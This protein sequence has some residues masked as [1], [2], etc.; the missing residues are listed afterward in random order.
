MFG[1]IS[2]LLLILCFFFSSRRRHTRCAL[3]TGVQT[4][5]LPILTAHISDCTEL[6]YC[7][8]SSRARSARDAIVMPDSFRHPTFHER[9]CL[10]SVGP[11]DKYGVTVQ[12]SFGASR[13]V[14]SYTTPREAFPPRQDRPTPA[15]A[16]PVR[17]PSPRPDTPHRTS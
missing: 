2:L 8:V 3:V 4:C 1:D 14:L 9:Q 7:A 17:S 16:T 15:A 10:R 11:R 13:G 6:R 12:I 5:A